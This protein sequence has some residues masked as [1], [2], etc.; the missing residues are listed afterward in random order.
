[1]PTMSSATVVKV[2]L[3]QAVAM[4]VLLSIPCAPANET[5]TPAGLLSLNT[6]LFYLMR[7]MTALK[8]TID[9]F[10]RN[11][12]MVNLDAVIGSRIVE[13]KFLVF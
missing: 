1:M 5:E 6:T 7:T 11:H 12:K 3:V 10:Q 2:R 4:L 13:G 9:F 8:G